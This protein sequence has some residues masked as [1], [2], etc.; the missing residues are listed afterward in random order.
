MSTAMRGKEILSLRTEN[1]K[2]YQTGPQK[3]RA[4]T[5][6]D[7][8]HYVDEKSG[9]YRLID[10]RLIQDGDHLYNKDNPTLQVELTP[11]S[12]SLRSAKGAGLSWYL[13]GAKPCPPRVVALETKEELDQIHSAAVYEEILPGADLRCEI[14]GVHFKDEIVFHT[15]ESAEKAVFELRIIE[16]SPR[17]EGED[18]L[19]TD[20]AG[21]TIF[22]LPPPVCMDSSKDAEPVQGSCKLEGTDR[23]DTWR[24]ICS[25]PEKWLESAAYPVILDP[26][27]VTYNARCAIQDAYTC[28]KQPGT[29]H[30][31]SS[32]NILRLTNG[33]SNWG[34]CLCFFKFDSS[35][36][37][38]LDASDYIV[39]A[40]FR[41]STAQSGYPTSAFTGT[42]REVTGNWAP[43]TLTH[44]NMPSCSDRVLDY[45]TFAASEGEGHIHT[46][47]VTNL[48]RKWY[49][50]TNYGLMLK[51][52]SN[53]YA[54]L[55]SSAFGQTDVNRPLVIIDYISKA[56][57]EDYLACEDHSAGRAGMGHVSLF[58]GNLIFEHGDTATDG[59]LMPIS[60]SHVYNSCY[61][62]LIVYGMGWGWK[63][64][65][66]QALRK[67]TISGALYYTWI[68]EDG[69]EVY[70]INSDGVWKDQLGKELTLTLGSIEA[71]IENK[72]G[73]KWI[74]ALPTAEFDNNWGNAK[75][76]LRIRN[77][78]GQQITLTGSGFATTKMMDAANRETKLT[79]TGGMLRGITAPGMT[80]GLTYRYS[81]DGCLVGIAHE[82]GFETVYTY[83][84]IHLLTQVRNLDGVTVQYTYTDI[85]PYR[86]TSVKVFNTQNGTEQVAFHHSY[87]YRD[88]LTIVTDQLSGKKIRYHFNDSGNLVALTDGLGYGAFAKYTTNG[89]LNRPEAI[90]R[91]QRSVVSLIRD[92]LFAG[93]IWQ[94]QANGAGSFAYDT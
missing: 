43:G 20:A 46:F 90:S 65:T 49:D 18:I 59:N 41:V 60:V 66:Q 19:L 70:F 75:P 8:I 72:Q 39:Y 80:S 26:A 4:V 81:N 44:N 16:L 94:Q 14:S 36:L 82:D 28:S 27:V 24:L 12:I 48:V 71:A 67:E 88:I 86:V 74:F 37:P 83:N 29:T 32:S 2:V 22:V 11:E 69:T 10:D 3:Y 42:L 52:E 45:S 9:E 51:A 15:P 17:Q 57:T 58:N 78:L 35:V 85:P 5:Y 63:L 40:E 77:A 73:T 6:L 56:G 89:P 87:E 50:G 76:L 47:E 25:L 79:W 31:G 61:G 64:N 62:N 84:S 54:Q 38:A 93:N 91:L 21:E 55:R 30:T 1:G 7:T 13:E 53:T 33:S 92:P 34:Q 23:T 68:D